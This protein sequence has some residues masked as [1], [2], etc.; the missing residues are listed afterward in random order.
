MAAEEGHVDIVKY[1]IQQ[2]VQVDAKNKVRIMCTIC[3]MRR[4]GLSVVIPLY[5]SFY[6]IVD[7]IIG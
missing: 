7:G 3:H 2:G 1:L 5:S 4:L 6:K